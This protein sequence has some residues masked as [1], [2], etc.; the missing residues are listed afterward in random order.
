MSSW[1]RCE[2]TQGFDIF[3]VRRLE[4]RQDHVANKMLNHAGDGFFFFFFLFM[5]EGTRQILNCLYSGVHLTM[6]D[7]RFTYLT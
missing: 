4:E 3:T 6:L 7:A 1:N 5:I 2:Y